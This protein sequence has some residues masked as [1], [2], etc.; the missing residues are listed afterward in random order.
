MGMLLKRKRDKANMTTSAVLNKTVEVET[1]K[2]I[3]KEKPI[4]KSF[5]KKS[6]KE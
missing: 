1:E 6:V 5:G 2:P 3:A 4:R